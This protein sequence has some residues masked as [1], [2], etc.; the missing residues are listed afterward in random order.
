[1]NSITIDQNKDEFIR[2]LKAQRVSYSQAKAIQKFEWVT[3]VISLIIPIIG[4][5]AL[6]DKYEQYALVL[7]TVFAIIYVITFFVGKKKTN[8]G[9][10]IQEQFDTE[11]F[12]IHWNDYLC[13]SR[14]NTKRILDLAKKYVNSDLKDWYSKE[15]KPSINKNMAILICQNSNLVWDNELRKK[16]VNAILFLV[17]L[18]FICFI[19]Y[20]LN[21]NK[22]FSQSLLLLIPIIPSLIY[23]IINIINQYDTIVNKRNLRE[24][25]I[26]LLE[27]YRDL[28]EEPTLANLRNVQNL[29]FIERNK[30]E[31]V[32][33]W[34]YNF[35]KKDMEKNMDEY[36]QVILVK[37]GLNNPN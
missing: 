31:K 22:T 19:I 18:Y 15:I 32:P 30:Q 14:V 6:P 2:L 12:G 26:G 36:I 28:K 8:E 34:F 13:G 23:L 1:M 11:L 5:S 7:G 20:L 35:F 17:I 4:F 25:V 21:I 37:F 29:I 9:A 16:L 33:N 10:R 24:K 27:K 3:Q